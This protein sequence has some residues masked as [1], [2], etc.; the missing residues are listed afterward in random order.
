MISFLPRCFA[1]LFG[2]LSV[3][4]LLATTG[5]L[6]L[7]RKLVTKKAIPRTGKTAV[8]AKPVTA[9]KATPAIKATPVIKATPIKIDPDAKT[10]D[11]KE[12]PPIEDQLNFANLLFSHKQYAIA[13]RKYEQFLNDNPK[14]PNAASAAF[15]LGECY[16]QLSQVV[17]AKQA[18]D[19]LI[20]QHKTGVY[21]GSAAFRL[22][23]LYINEKNY[24]KALPYFDTAIKNIKNPKLEVQAIYYGARCL[25]LSGKKIQAIAIYEELMEI[26]GQGPENP[27]AEPSLLAIARLYAE[28]EDNT[29]ALTAFKNVIAHSKDPAH[30]DEAYARGG[31]IAAKTR[32]ARGEQSTAGQG[33]AK[34]IR[35]NLESPG[36]DRPDL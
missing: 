17:Q 13:I 25:Q 33:V 15:R 34:R 29:K 8:K 2:C 31:L 26:Q 21:T 9:D 32:Q 20:K 36:P 1:D 7:V 12:G 35:E 19:R 27:F 28:L 22:A 14:S 3:C 10:K 6:F 5:I 24:P 18:Y 16:L 11:G 30:L 23:T 4:V